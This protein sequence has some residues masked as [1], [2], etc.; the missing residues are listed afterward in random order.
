[1][2]RTIEKQ[3]DGMMVK[4]YL[5]GV[6]HSSRAQITRLKALERGIMLNGERVTVRAV[7]REGDILELQ[8]EANTDEINSLIARA[9]LP[10][11]IL[12]EDDDILAVN[13]PSGMPT[14]PTHGHYDD[15]LANAV[16]DH[17]ALKGIPFVFRAVNRLDRNTSG[18][19][20]IA[21]NGMAAAYLGNALSSGKFRKTYIAFLCGSLPIGKG[22][23]DR[24]I[25]RE[26]ES[27]ITRTVCENGE[28]DD[29]VTLYEVIAHFDD[30]S[31]VFATPLTGRTHQLRVHFASIGHPILGDDLYGQAD[32]RIRRQALHAYSL[33][34]P[35]PYDG[36]PFIV[37]APMPD[38]MKILLPE[39]KIDQIQNIF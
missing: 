31:V 11:T 15:T 39:G 27:I 21:K 33:T 19:V 1:M 34:F 5:Y 2:R 37:T 28:G 38:D 3:Q 13:K 8:I 25:R 12:A 35:H 10:F 16:I 14:H 17:Y 7:L 9:C 22:M 26:K 6:L 36:T 24:P 23:I 4:Q 18:V 32:P 30:F 29:A 20:L